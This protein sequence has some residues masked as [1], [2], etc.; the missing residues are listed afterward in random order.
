MQAAGV[1]RIRRGDDAGEAALAVVG[2]QYLAVVR[3]EIEQP[4]PGAEAHLLGT[5]VQR[6][7]Q[8][9]IAA[10]VTGPPLRGQAPQRRVDRIGVAQRIEVDADHVHAG[11]TQRGQVG[12]GQA[13]V[14]VVDGIAEHQHLQAG[15]RALAC[16][17]RVAQLGRQQPR[18]SM[19]TPRCALNRKKSSTMYSCAWPMTRSMASK[20][21][22]STMGAP[23]TSAPVTS[24]RKCSCSSGVSIPSPRHARW[25]LGMGL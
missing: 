2:Q 12:R 16:Q 9:G 17:E 18:G 10:A 13:A 14:H 7:G 25:P 6:V 20:I 11:G 1:V 5:G 4:R 8:P 19:F 21:C 15:Q 23:N 22:C 24:V 3:L